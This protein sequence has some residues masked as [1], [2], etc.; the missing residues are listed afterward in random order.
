VLVNGRVTHQQKDEVA[1]LMEQQ[2]V[3]RSAAR[4]VRQTER[5][6]KILG[7]HTSNT[8]VTLDVDLLLLENLVD[9]YAPPGADKARLQW[10]AALQKDDR[11]AGSSCRHVCA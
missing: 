2:L 4:T 10:R 9:P 11:W 6:I 8:G 3:D 1:R 7:L 5:C